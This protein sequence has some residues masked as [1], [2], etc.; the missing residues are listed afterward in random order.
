VDAFLREPKVNLQLLFTGA[1]HSNA[2]RLSRKVRPH[3]FQT[4]QRVFQL[5]QLDRESRFV[6]SRAGRE[7]VEDQL[8][9]VEH[10]GARRLFEIADLSRREVVVEHDDVRIMTIDHRPQLSHFSFAQIG[11]MIGRTSPL[12]QFVDNVGTGRGRQS[13]EFLEWVRRNL[14]LRQDKA[15]QDAPFR[16]IILDLIW[17]THDLEGGSSSVSRSVSLIQL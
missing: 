6:S 17:F 5:S 3:P 2:H 4:R 14:V 16:R 8:G 15:C 7:N 12:D 10:F 9:P 11:R 1:A 13:M